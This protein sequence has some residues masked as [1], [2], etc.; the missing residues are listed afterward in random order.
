[1]VF[2]AAILASA[3][4]SDTVVSYLLGFRY[5]EFRKCLEQ[6]FEF[7]TGQRGRH[8]DPQLVDAFVGVRDEVQR[9]QREL[10]DPEVARA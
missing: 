10:R 2:G 3:G 7:L 9:I 8:F 1:M 5:L 6:A 4:Q